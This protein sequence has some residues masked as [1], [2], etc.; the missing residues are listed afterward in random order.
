[1]DMRQLVEGMRDL[2]DDLAESMDRESDNDVEAIVSITSNGGGLLR[3]RAFFDNIR[4]RFDAA[5]QGRVRTPPGTHR[6]TWDV[7]G[8]R[9]APVRILVEVDGI[10][11][12]DEGGNLGD[13][14]RDGGSF[15]FT[16]E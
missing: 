5:G 10:R 2:L 6:L 1:M 16:I 4:I 3:T 11:V 7:Q 15:V 12:A 8:P 9:N 14:G 13:D